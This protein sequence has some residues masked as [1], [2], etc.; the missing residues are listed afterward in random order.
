[1]QKLGKSLRMWIQQHISNYWIVLFPFLCRMEKH[2][3]DYYHYIENFVTIKNNFIPEFAPT[4]DY[5]MD[6]NTDS[7]ESD[8][9]S[10]NEGGHSLQGY[11]QYNILHNFV[12]ICRHIFMLYYLQI[13]LC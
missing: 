11:S 6:T 12:L 13:Y 2:R 9:R 5:D 10:D 3:R 8:G 1:M 4:E 7:S